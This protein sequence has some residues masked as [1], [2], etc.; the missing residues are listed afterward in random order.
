MDC[1]AP[2][3]GLGLG[4][5]RGAAAAWLR[6]GSAANATASGTIGLIGTIDPNGHASLKNTHA[7]RF[8][9]ESANSCPLSYPAGVPPPDDTT[10]PMRAD[11]RRF[12]GCRS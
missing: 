10:T 5:G 1:R 3:R 12:F 2:R 9:G 11:G 4:R 6:E 8:A 7:S